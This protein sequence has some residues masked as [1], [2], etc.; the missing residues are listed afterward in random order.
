MNKRLWIWV[1]AV[2][3]VFAAVITVVE[4]CSEHSY[5]KAILSSKLEGYA[6]IVSQTDD[7]SRTTSLLPRDIRVSVITLDGSVLYDSYEPTQVLGNHLT[8]PEIKSCLNEKDG[9][10]IRKS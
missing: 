9:C 3:A 4:L 7:Y 2:F 10:S 8:R 6:D 5:K 1:T